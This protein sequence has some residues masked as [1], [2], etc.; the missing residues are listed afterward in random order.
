MD[1]VEF[2][3]ILDLFPVVRSPDYHLKEWQDAWDVED[4]K[5]IKIQGIDH[6][7]AFWKKLRLAAG[8]KVSAAEAEGF[9]KSFQGVY[10]RL[11]EEL[12]LDAAQSFIN[13]SKHNH[14]A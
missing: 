8:K 12:S 11:V 6:H 3:R 7:D 1:E 5:E 9:C 13:A 4:K 14:E 10:K 2:Q